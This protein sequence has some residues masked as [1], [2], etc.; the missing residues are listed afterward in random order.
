MPL[1]APL[2]IAA[3]TIPINVRAGLAVLRGSAAGFAQVIGAMQFTRAVPTT[4][5]A[6]FFGYFSIDF[7]QQLM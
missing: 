1:A 4:A 7:L 2:L 3:K 6:D 5:L